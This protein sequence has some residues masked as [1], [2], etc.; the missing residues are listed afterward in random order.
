MDVLHYW[1]SDQV[2]RLLDALASHSRHQPRTA[3]LIMWR[4]GLRTS[5]VLNLEWRDLDYLGAPPTLLV[6]RSKTRRALVVRL[7]P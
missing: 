3:P 2:S 4:S 5:K 7:H 1:T 6:R